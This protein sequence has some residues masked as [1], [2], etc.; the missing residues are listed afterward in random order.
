LVEPKGKKQKSDGPTDK[1]KQTK[2]K[3]D[4]VQKKQ[5]KEASQLEVKPVKLSDSQQAGVRS[6]QSQ[7]FEEKPSVRWM[8]DKDQVAP[9]IKSP[10]RPK[11]A[12]DNP[13]E[14]KKALEAA[15]NYLEE[16]SQ[17]FIFGIEFVIVIP[18]QKIHPPPATMCYR[19]ERKDHVASITENIC[20]NQGLEPKPADMLVRHN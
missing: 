18:V 1:P 20:S 4:G 7:D 11:K 12:S 6:Q 2:A 16:I 17:Y 13:K 5:K 3:K 8:E 19:G 14:K 10:S 9:T 15:R